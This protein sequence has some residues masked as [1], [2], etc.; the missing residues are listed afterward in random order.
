MSQYA[1]PIPS[2]LRDR[3]TFKSSARVEAYPTESRW[4]ETLRTIL[5]WIQDPYIVSNEDGESPQ[6]EVLRLAYHVATFFRNANREAPTAVVPDGNCGVTLEW[7]EG[8]NSRWI[9][10]SSSGKIEEIVIGGGRLQSRNEIPSR[11]F[12]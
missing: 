2:C 7:R 6:R 3:Q 10:I 5:K 9:E 1:P 11:T 4:E 8:R 12:E